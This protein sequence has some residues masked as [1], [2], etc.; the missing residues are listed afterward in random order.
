MRQTDTGRN[1]E[2]EGLLR[3]AISFLFVSAGAGL[4]SPADQTPF[5]LIKSVE[6]FHLSVS[7]PPCVAA[8]SS[9]PCLLTVSFSNL[10]QTLTT[11]SCP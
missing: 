7:R 6:I 1:K 8:A 9:E 2:V 5:P 11:S 4:V 10:H 3:Q